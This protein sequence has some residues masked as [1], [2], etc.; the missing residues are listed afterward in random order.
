MVCRVKVGLCSMFLTRHTPWSNFLSLPEPRFCVII[1]IRL[2]DAYFHQ[3]RWHWAKCFVDCPVL[4]GCETCSFI[5]GGVHLMIPGHGRG[6]SLKAGEECLGG[7]SSSHSLCV[8]RSLPSK[9]ERSLPPPPASRRA[10]KLRPQRE[11][12]SVGGLPL[13]GVLLQL[14]CLQPS[15]GGSRLAL[16]ECLLPRGTP[17]WQ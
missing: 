16:A 5:M 2:D 6:R 1:I 7:C 10:D 13:L 3:R 8:L 9:A 17:E 14:Y 11:G 15:P 4:S 12:K